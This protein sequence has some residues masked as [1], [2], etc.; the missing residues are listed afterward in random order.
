[1]DH[2]TAKIAAFAAQLDYAQLTDAA[3]LHTREVMLASQ[4]LAERPPEP[5][6]P[7]E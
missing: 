2:S 4:Q 6:D 1:M 3:R 5:E 7:S